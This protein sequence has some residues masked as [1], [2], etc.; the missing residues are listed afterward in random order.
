MEY[1]GQQM[2]QHGSLEPWDGISPIPDFDG[3][4]LPIVTQHIKLT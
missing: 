3:R 2:Q 4:A 1:F